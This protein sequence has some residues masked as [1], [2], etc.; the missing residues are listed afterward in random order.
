MKSDSKMT[1]TGTRRSK[2]RPP[3]KSLAS[4]STVSSSTEAVVDFDKNWEILQNAISQIQ[5][6]NVSN[7]SY[8]QLYR[9][10][11]L[12]V[13]RKHGEQLYEKVAETVKEHLLQQR[14]NLLQT[15]VNAEVFM[16]A[17]LQEW[18]E[19]LQSMKFVGDVLMY[20][21]RV[22][23]KEQKRLLIYDLGIQL[24]KDNVIMYNN[25]EVGSKM[26]E[27]ILDEIRKSRN[28]E[29][30]T[31]NMYITKLI[32]MME[33]LIENNYASEISF[34]DNYY[35]TI[36]EPVFLSSSESYF[37]DLVREFVSLNLGSKYLH[38]VTQF[39]RSEENRIKMYLPLSSHSKLTNLMNNILIKDKID[40]IML[41]SNEGLDYWLKP[42]LH[43]AL[44]NR[45][46]PELY[47]FT[48]L[49]MLYHLVGRIDDEYQILRLR[50]K[51]AI[52]SQGGTLPEW[53]R[54]SLDSSS[55]SS[56]SVSS[57]SSEKKTS[58]ASQTQFAI[59]WIELV[60]KYRAQIME[61]WN[62]SFEVNFMI[63]QTLAFA[64]RDFING[65]NKR[66]KNEINAPE[67]LSIYIDYNIKQ[68][69]KGSSA[70]TK[71]NTNTNINTSTNTTT[72]IRT[73]TNSGINN[74]GT[75]ISSHSGDEIENLINNSIQILRFVKD[76]DAFEAYYA[77]HFAKRFLNSKSTLG[78]AFSKGN[79][80][81]EMILSKLC[82]EMGTTSLDKVIKMSKDIKISNDTT[83]GWKRYLAKANIPVSNLI[84]LDLKICNVAVWPKSLTKDYKSFEKTERAIEDETIAG[85]G[86]RNG[87]GTENGDDTGTKFVWPRQLRNTIQEFE[88]YW[89]SGKKNDNRSLH[90]SPKFGSIDMRITYPSRTY[91]INLP[92]FA[93]IIMLL[94]AP[95][96]LLTD[97]NG[98][99]KLAFE[100]RKVLSYTEIVELTGIPLQELKRH[101]QSI[102]VAPRLR[103]LVKS[104]MSKEVND[105]DTFRLN[106]K[107]KSPT[108]KVKVL[109]VSLASS[110]S[111]ASSLSSSTSSSSKMSSSLATATAGKSNKKTEQ[112][113]E[114]AEVNA[115]IIEGRK[116]ELNAAIVRI[117][118]SRRTVSHNELI[119][120]LIRQ[121]SNRFQP[122][123]VM[124]K[125]RIEDLIE[126]EYLKRDDNDRNLYH[127]IA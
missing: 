70:N 50:L 113:E 97:K 40:G 80:V 125:Q 45:G 121:L 1:P 106:E 9:K 17:L 83:N 5:N 14:A 89:S 22:Y 81:E 66:G 93:A 11:Y 16:Q 62:R 43:N 49:K 95:Q 79:D 32:S 71:T 34:G 3:R 41:A 36:F 38:S 74:I 103:L 55:S 111:S 61:M 48:D 57:S 47:H 63:E 116:I 118:K 107:F 52:T 127:Y 126:K 39:I 59:K 53:V 46:N 117:L 76:K 54:N 105:S 37:T 112:E 69:G 31:S 114:T 12:L 6:K 18:D 120:G 23:V 19:H 110:S 108:T 67:L 72:T 86:N 115:Q 68:L 58:S 123:V 60:L 42:I 21:N 96:S 26:T 7:L 33:L 99:C 56:S 119:E 10:A 27:I 124:M 109:T 92:V 98:P 100:E 101:L 85:S 94:F 122:T 102:A 90:W 88:E 24:F 82:E 77:N 35:Q 78:S 84:D 15:S 65:T 25:N 28:G 8:E 20:L 73:T 75:G 64:I 13:I 104:P 51:D 30:I 44:Q 87:N 2:I 4:S 91:D 29:V